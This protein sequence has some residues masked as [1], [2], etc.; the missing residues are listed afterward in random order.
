ML[1]VPANKILLT[2]SLSG[3]ATFKSMNP[4]VPEQPDEIAQQAYDCYNEGACIVHIH[5]RDEKGMPT[6]DPKVFQNIK[7]KIRGKGVQAIMQFSTGGGP[8]LNL[9]Q[10][11]TCLDALPESAS[12]NMGTLMRVAGEYKD[13]PWL[14]SRSDVARFAARMKELGIK[15]EMEIFSPTFFREVMVLAKEGLIEKPYHV[16]LVF[17]MSYQ[18]AMES[19]PKHLN[20]ILEFVPDDTYVNI[21]GVGAAQLPL[22]TMGMIYGCCIRVGMEDNIYYSKGVLAKS[23]AEL[24]ARTVRIARELGKEP[25]SPAEAREFLGIK[26]LDT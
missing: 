24:V 26:P 23:N 12:L 5:A 4:N 20:S 25:M 17:G 6:G 13:V 7:E 21:S 22:T 18:G 10:R 15:P 11:L 8:G 3:A 2:V 1:K 16:N 14:N 9:E 19:T